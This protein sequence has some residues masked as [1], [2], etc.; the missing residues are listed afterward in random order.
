[1]FENL[2]ND[3]LLLYCIKAY[4]KPNCIMSEFEEDIKRFNY[5][6]R[7]F[8]RYKKTGEFRERL[9]INHLIILCNIFG[10]EVTVRV[11]FCKIFEEH[12][13]ELKTYLLFLNIMPKVVKGIMGRD[14]ISSDI[15]VDMEIVE[16]LRKIK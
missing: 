4:D 8:T 11:A 13:S 14:I 5:I 1:M 16:V 3:N 7:L 15:S 6:N 10:P 9:I 12:Y 2:D